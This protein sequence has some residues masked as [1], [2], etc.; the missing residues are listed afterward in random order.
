[1][2]LKITAATAAF[3][4]LNGAALADTTVS[5]EYASGNL[6]LNGPQGSGKTAGLRL[7]TSNGS[8]LLSVRLGQARETAFNSA[9]PQSITFPGLASVTG[10]ADWNKQTR[11][12]FIEVKKSFR[13]FDRADV[14]YGAYAG[15]ASGTAE[16]NAAAHVALHAQTVRIPGQTYMGMTLPATTITLPGSTRDVQ[17]HKSRSLKSPYGGALVAAELPLPTSTHTQLRLSASGQAGADRVGY[18]AGAA[19]VVTTRP[20]RDD[21]QM[22]NGACSGKPYAPRN[23]LALTLAVCAD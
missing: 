5:A 10:N 16:Y 21:R 1:M 22:P 9:A 8:G 7:E 4:L 6:L 20:T 12:D 14:S 17:Q 11:A 3:A 15:Q 18:G 13:V 2:S 23:G 19:F